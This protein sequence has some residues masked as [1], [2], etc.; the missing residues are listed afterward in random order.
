MKPRK[1]EAD[2]S[3]DEKPELKIQSMEGR[4]KCTANCWTYEVVFKCIS[5]MVLRVR[6]TAIKATTEDTWLLTLHSPG[7]EP[8]ITHKPQ[9]GPLHARSN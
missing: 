6:I 8:S 1:F 7:C 2:R 9:K 3:S 4:T 5:N